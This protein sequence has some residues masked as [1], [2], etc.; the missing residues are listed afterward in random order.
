[1][2]NSASHFPSQP[3]HQENRPVRPQ[4]LQRAHHDSCVARRQGAS[5]ILE[6]DRGEIVDGEHPNVPLDANQ[7]EA[8]AERPQGDARSDWNQIR[9][10]FQYV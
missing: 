6:D 7:H 2:N 9:M 8:D 3:L 5:S 1:M 4:Q 10:V